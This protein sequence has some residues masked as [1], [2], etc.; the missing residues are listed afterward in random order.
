ML[1]ILKKTEHIIVFSQQKMKNEHPI[2]KN[3][4][5]LKKL[6]NSLNKNIALATKSQNECLLLFIYLKHLQNTYLNINTPHQPS[7]NITKNQP[8]LDFPSENV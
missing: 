7:Q 1:H 4:K 2:R 6:Q 3:R 5:S 8:P